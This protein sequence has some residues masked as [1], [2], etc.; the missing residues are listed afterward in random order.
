MPPCRTHSGLQ[1]LCCRTHSFYVFNVCKRTAG[2]NSTES[3]R[4]SGLVQKSNFL[5]EKCSLLTLRDSSVAATSRHQRR[6]HHR[7]SQG[8]ARCCSV[9]ITR[10]HEIQ[11]D[12]LLPVAWI[13]TGSWEKEEKDCISQKELSYKFDI[14]RRVFTDF[15][16]L[17]LISCIFI[18]LCDLFLAC[19]RMPLLLR[20]AGTGCIQGIIFF[21]VLGRS[22]F[23]LPSTFCL[24]AGLIVL[25]SP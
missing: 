2:I 20:V 24:G 22:C 13:P 7:S 6:F 4:I 10:L 17:L 15:N 8:S 3:C 18:H 23:L 25:P 16:G 12:F 21:T 19:Q 1:C 9:T 5:Y 11:K 14:N